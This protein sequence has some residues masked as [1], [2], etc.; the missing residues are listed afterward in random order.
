MLFATRHLGERGGLDGRAYGDDL[1]GV[2]SVE[3]GRPEELLDAAP[4][5]WNARRASHQDDLVERRNRQP[6]HGESLLADRER[7][8]DERRRQHLELV[9]SHPEV[10]IEMGPSGAERDLAH[11]DPGALAR[12]QLD[13]HAPSAAA[14]RRSKA[15]ASERG[16]DLGRAGRPRPCARRWP[17]RDRR[18]RGSC[19]RPLRAP[20]TRSPTGRGGCSRTCLRRSRRPRCAL[21]STARA[22]KPER[23]PWVR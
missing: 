16:S 3:R 13:L 2:H 11:F 17:R 10:E 5:E 22:R 21:W 9:A 19:R 23:P 6:R 14:R 4:H 1:L 20:R 15:W 8:L 7:A 12:R 18:R